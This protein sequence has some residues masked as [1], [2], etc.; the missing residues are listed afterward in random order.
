MSAIKLYP[1]QVFV[2]NNQH[3]RIQ[4]GVINED[5]LGFSVT[6]FFKQSCQDVLED[7]P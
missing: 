3:T 2:S 4:G 1:V 7:M 5:I 6:G